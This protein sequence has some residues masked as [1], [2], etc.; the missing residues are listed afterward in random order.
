MLTS[1]LLGV[2]FA[3]KFSLMRFTPSVSILF[4]IGSDSTAQAGPQLLSL[5]LHL[6]SAE[7]LGKYH[8]AQLLLKKQY[9]L[10]NECF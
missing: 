1:G 7:I 4:A 8:N 9:L 10:K 2:Y 3:N 6:P 5:L